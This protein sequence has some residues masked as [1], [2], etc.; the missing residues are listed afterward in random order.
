M[1]CLWIQTLN[2]MKEA[3]RPCVK[4]KACVHVG[5]FDV[6]M[7]ERGKA[8]TRLFSESRFKKEKW[9]KFDLR[10]HKPAMLIFWPR[11]FSAH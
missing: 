11:V 9:Q 10:L 3:A 1:M 5:E 6:I 4:G 8:A 7:S 2:K